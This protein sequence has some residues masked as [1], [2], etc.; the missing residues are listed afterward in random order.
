MANNAPSPECEESPPPPKRS[1]Y[2]ELGVFFNKVIAEMPVYLR[3]P[4][5][6]DSEYSLKRVLGADS[7]TDRRLVLV[8]KWIKSR[9][10]QLIVEF[11]CFSFQER[12]SKPCPK[13]NARLP[14]PF[15]TKQMWMDS[16]WSFWSTWQNILD[17]RWKLPM[18][19]RLDGVQSTSRR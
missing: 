15:A 11:P 8:G 2:C 17:E 4:P 7:P 12:F 18:Q 16:Q 1:R 5:G 6:A 19:W 10:D 3:T 13:R 9:N 14:C